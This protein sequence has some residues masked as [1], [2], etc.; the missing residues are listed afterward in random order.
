MNQ[1]PTLFICH[2]NES[3]RNFLRLFFSQYKDKLEIIGEC[4]NYSECQNWLQNNP[5]DFVIIALPVDVMDS[6]YLL[7]ILAEQFP[8]TEFIGNSEAGANKLVEFHQRIQAMAVP[9]LEFA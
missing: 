2:W 4:R 9:E 8:K 3:S 5:A 6:E 1:K 7:E